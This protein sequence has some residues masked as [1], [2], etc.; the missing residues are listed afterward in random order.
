ME[1]IPEKNGKPRKGIRDRIKGKDGHVR[2][3][4]MGKRVDYSARTVLT[5]DP[6][7]RTDEI[8]IP[9][10]FI[11]TLTYPE[12]V[13]VINI[14]T[15]EKL[16]NNGGAVRVKYTRQ[17]RGEMRCLTSKTKYATR[18]RGTIIKPGDSLERRGV[19]IDNVSHIMPLKDD[20]VT[21]FT[22]PHARHLCYQT[23]DIFVRDEV[24]FEISKMG[25]PIVEDGDVISRKDYNLEKL[26]RETITQADD[27]I[28]IHAR[29]HQKKHFSLQ[30]GDVVYRHLRDGDKVLFNRQP[31]LHNGSFQVLTVRIVRQ[32]SRR[33]LGATSIRSS[34]DQ[35][36]ITLPLS[37]TKPLGADFDG[38][39]GNIHAPQSEAAKTELA[40][41]ASPS[42]SFTSSQFGNCNI[43]LVQ[44]AVLGCYLMTNGWNVVERND[45]FRCAMAGDGWTPAFILQRIAHN[46][47]IYRELGVY[48]P[49]YEYSGKSLFSIMLPTDFCYTTKDVKILKGVLYEGA[50]TKTLVGGGQRSI[51]KLLHKEYPI[52]SALQFIN[53][54]QFIPYE[55]LATEGF[56]VGLDDCSGVDKKDVDTIIAKNLMNA[57]LIEKTTH[58]PIIRES[59]VR[60][61]LSQAKDN[62]MLLAKKG[63]KDD[64]AFRVMVTAG[65]KGDY[66]NI[67]QIGGLM[68]QQNI[69]GKRVVASMNGGRRSLPH[70]PFEDDD[71]KRRY[72]SRGF[73]GSSFTSGL[74][75]QEMFFAA[76][77]GREGVVDTGMKTANSGYIQRKMVNIAADTKVQYD[78]TVRNGDQ[79]I[80]FVYGGVDGFD[81]KNVIHHG[82]ETDFCDL[83]RLVDKLNAQHEMTN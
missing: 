80:Q 12:N 20:R 40:R 13:N 2:G 61:C 25:F 68:G 53:S 81:G 38:D 19:T 67:C 64:N 78:G 10:Y 73:I 74:S 1:R 44:D 35:K 23:G 54:A 34:I 47:Q 55:W 83:A 75:P 41:L 24:R 9:E 3:C 11:T 22:P 70:Y 49:G 26:K 21:R 79:I 28:K 82:E 62:G 59:K 72:E 32:S 18:N 14:E 43:S 51:N 6:T 58:D 45:F 17:S 42:G 29:P 30:V 56:S 76:M 16:V 39:E 69:G 46:E 7:L 15:L 4:M 57:Q 36:T 50:I 37:V 60:M 66:F 5:G 8:G 52:Q 77:A 31:T 65:S 71:V 48:K 63:M 33:R 27:C